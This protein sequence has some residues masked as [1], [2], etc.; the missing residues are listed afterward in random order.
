MV[1]IKISVYTFMEIDS[2]KSFLELLVGSFRR[3]SLPLLQHGVGTHVDSTGLVNGDGLEDTM[4]ESQFYAE[5][6]P[7][8]VDVTRYGE[9][10]LVVANH[11]NERGSPLPFGQAPLGDCCVAGSVSP[12]LAAV[13]MRGACEGGVPLGGTWLL[14]SRG[15]ASL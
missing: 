11:S 10:E 8:V 3:H 5:L 4:T 7:S 6:L 9:D 15:S 13:C 14:R 1:R 2:L 12:L